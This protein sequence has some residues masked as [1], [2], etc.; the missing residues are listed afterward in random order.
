MTIEL[1]PEEIMRI[2]EALAIYKSH[3]DS[4]GDDDKSREYKALRMKIDSL[5]LK[6][7]MEEQP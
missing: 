6:N 4:Y 5:V 1:S 2:G 7:A 3:V